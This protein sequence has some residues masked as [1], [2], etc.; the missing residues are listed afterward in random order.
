MS[1]KQITYP[2]SQKLEKVQPNTVALCNVPVIYI[3]TNAMVARNIL[4]TYMFTFI[5][6]CLEGVDRDYKKSSLGPDIL[7]LSMGSTLYGFM[8]SVYL[9]HGYMLYS[10]CLFH[11]YLATKWSNEFELVNKYSVAMRMMY[12][13]YWTMS[14]NPAT[15]ELVEDF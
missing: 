11:A 14:L 4:L 7:I 1:D 3:L 12:A 8:C 13:V 15:R 2:L 10:F 6:A 9:I 5:S